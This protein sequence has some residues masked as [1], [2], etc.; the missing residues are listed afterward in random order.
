MKSRIKE[1]ESREEI[2]FP[3]MMKSIG[4]GN[5]VLFT[6]LGEG[7]MVHRCDGPTGLGEY[8]RLWSMPRF[9]DFDGEVTLKN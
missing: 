3:K 2:P 5:I 8:D 9:E 1:A 6:K 4:S 7:V